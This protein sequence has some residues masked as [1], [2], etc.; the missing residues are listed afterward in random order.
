MNWFKNLDA[1]PRLLL[2]FGVLNVL[3]AAMSY[4]AIANLG[5]RKDGSLFPVEGFVGPLSAGGERYALAFLAPA[6]GDW[7][8]AR[9][10]LDPVRYAALHVADDVAYGAGVWFGCFRAR[11]VTPLIPRIELRTRMWS[12][13]SL[14]AQL[15][16]R[17]ERAMER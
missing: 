2:S 5:V 4:L 17:K 12:T 13:R 3:I 9:R 10:A 7:L 8:A 15:G 1:T 16:D 11:T 14:R 6:A